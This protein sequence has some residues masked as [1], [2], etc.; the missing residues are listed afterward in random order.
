MANLNVKF[1]TEDSDEEEEERVPSLKYYCARL[2]YYI[3]LNIMYNL[4]K[5]STSTYNCECRKFSGC[6]KK[7]KLMDYCDYCSLAAKHN[8]FDYDK[9]FKIKNL[10]NEHIELIEDFKKYKID[11]TNEDYTTKMWSPYFYMFWFYRSVFCDSLFID[12]KTFY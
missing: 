3:N 1:F 2:I 5:G 9:D 11:I 12:K 10:I 6:R 4:H 8:P 7:N